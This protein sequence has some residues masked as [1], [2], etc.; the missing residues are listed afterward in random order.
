MKYSVMKM[1]RGVRRRLKRVVQKSSDKDYARRALALLHLHESGNNV[2][3]AASAVCAARSS[4][5]AWRSLYEMYGEDGIVPQRRGRVAWKTC[6][7][8]LSELKVLLERRPGDYGYLR[9]RWSS[10]LLALV[11]RTQ[12]RIEVHATTIRRWLKRMSFGW[13]RARPTLFKRD[14]RKL[15]RMQAIDAALQ[16]DRAGAE[17]FYVDEVDVHLNPK[18]GYG[19][20]RRGCQEAV[21]TPGQNQKAYLAGA[22]HAKTGR[23]VFVEGE[24]KNSMLF[25]GLLKQLKRTYRAA[26]RIVLI[27]DNYKIHS[28][29]ITQRWLAGNGKFQLLFQPAYHPWVNRIERLWKAMHDTVTRNHRHPAMSG[30]MHAVRRF[31][32]VCQPFPGNLHALALA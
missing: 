18:I 14:P 25:I 11:L 24:R 5:Q 8:A 29:R 13:R 4:V 3:A 27:L 10:E 22:L 26:R 12:A 20:M 1:A 31:M 23:V 32:D 15:A 17:V 9:S 6:D 2:T 16:A 21:P 19:W 7:N 30:L 28:S